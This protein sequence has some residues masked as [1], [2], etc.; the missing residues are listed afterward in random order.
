MS[1]PKSNRE[2]DM[3]YW[4][5]LEE[6]KRRLIMEYEVWWKERDEDFSK[7]SLKEK[8]EKVKALKDFLFAHFP[9]ELLDDDI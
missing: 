3:K 4:E 2:W 1:T 5:E 8:R 6:L 9:Q 7:E